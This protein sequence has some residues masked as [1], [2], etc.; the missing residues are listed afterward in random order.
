MVTEAI[1]SYKTNL[2]PSLSG[3]AWQGLDLQQ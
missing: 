3:K 1:L 2:L